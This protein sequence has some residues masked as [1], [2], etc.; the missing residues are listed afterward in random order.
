MAI[1]VMAEAELFV[2]LAEADARRFAIEAQV[3]AAKSASAFDGP[4]QHGG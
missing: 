2:N 3:T 4:L 1:A